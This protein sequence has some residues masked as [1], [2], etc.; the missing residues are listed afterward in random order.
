MTET[1][2][3]KRFRIARDKAAANG[4]TLMMGDGEFY[5]S[6]IPHSKER[7]ILKNLQDVEIFVVGYSLGYRSSLK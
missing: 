2:T 7:V 1:G 6:D 5:F 4:I 3:I